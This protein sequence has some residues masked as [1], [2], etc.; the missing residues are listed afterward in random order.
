MLAQLLP[1]AAVAAGATNAYPPHREEHP[2]PHTPLYSPTT[3]HHDAICLLVVDHPRL[4]I[5]AAECDGHPR[6]PVLQ[7]EQVLDQVPLAAA[8]LCIVAG[9]GAA[10]Q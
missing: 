9:I 1:A 3:T 6:P 4:L 2:H 5:L 8:A 7:I 10:L